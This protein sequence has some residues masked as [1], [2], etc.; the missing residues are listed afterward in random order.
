MLAPLERVEEAW[1]EEMTAEAARS[2]RLACLLGSAAFVVFAFVDP[3]LAPGALRELITARVLIIAALLLLLLSTWAR[4]FPRWAWHAGVL[5]CWL[6]GG[7]VIVVTA[8][9]GGAAT[10]YHEALL[11]TLFGF[12]L[13]PLPWTW[14]QS[15]L[16]YLGLVITYILTMYVTHRTGTPAEWWS[17]TAVL[18]SAVGIAGALVR[19]AGMLRRNEVALRLAMEEGNTQLRDANMRLKELDHAKSQFFANL[20]HELRTPL[21][22]ALAPIDALLEGEAELPSSMRE[23]LALARRSALRMMRLVDDL[24]MLSRLESAALPAASEPVDLGRLLTALLEEVAPLAR[25]KQIRLVWRPPGREVWVVGDATWLERALMNVVANALKFSPESSELVVSLDAAGGEARL[26]VADQGPGIPPDQLQRVFE[27]FYQVD[28]SATRAH[29]GIGIGLA[30]ARELLELHGGRIV[31]ESDGVRGTTMVLTLPTSRVPTAAFTLGQKPKAG[32]AEWHQ[33]LTM[34]PEYR[35]LDVDDATERR[36]LPR[37]GV[38]PGR[39]A[40]LVIEDNTDM[41]RLLGGLL[42]ADYE[43]FTARDGESGLRMVHRNRPELIICDVMMPGMSGLEVARTLREDPETRNI[44]ILLLTARA[45]AE[46]RLEAQRQGA[47]GWLTK[48]FRRTE[49]LSTVER[50]LRNQTNRQIAAER[51][52]EERVHAVIVGVL[53][54]LEEV[55]GALASAGADVSPLAAL[56]DRLRPMVPGPAQ[57]PEDVDPEVAARAALAPL[58][59]E[60]L[61]RIEL[62]LDSRRRVRAV[63]GDLERILAELV[64]N[65]LDASP[66]AE[67]VEV[68]VREEAAEIRIEVRDH[69][70]GVP[71]NVRD[72]VFQ[73]FYTTRFA[74]PRA[75]LGLAIARS[76]ARRSGGTLALETNFGSGSRFVLRLPARSDEPE[77]S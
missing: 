44:P 34:T 73:P 14:V 20:S 77:L 71:A 51:R 1:R 21:T 47:D 42:G 49:L 7:G 64:R 35:L 6:I 3:W 59:P 22:L 8:L 38:A 39:P 43:V 61:R 25:R 63:P 24:L 66:E 53:R 18:F 76:L 37:R 41:I 30:L 62:S 55:A 32:I 29:G 48:P 65:A 70:P 74:E 33:Q 67:R 57:R 5:S 54:A 69:G 31:A 15:S 72:S 40:V 56:V 17:T 10:R 16:N 4:G 50:M 13:L 75:G 26:R 12:S 58:S 27:R 60:E 2:V 9:V 36:V 28:G 19:T 45:D 68:A 52:G 11:L 46:T 23:D